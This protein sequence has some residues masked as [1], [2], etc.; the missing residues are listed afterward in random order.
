MELVPEDVLKKLD[1][2]VKAQQTTITENREALAKLLV[3]TQMITS[4]LDRFFIQPNPTLP[5]PNPSPHTIPPTSPFPSMS[6]TD[7]PPKAFKFSFLVFSDKDPYKWLQKCEQFFAFH[8]TP[9][10]QLLCIA[11][12]HMDGDA[13]KW[14]TWHNSETPFVDWLDFKARENSTLR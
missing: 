9:V 8:S 4:K 7:N 14:F 10:N 6:H 11:S 2:T 12:F 1:A 3:D 13:L 5:L